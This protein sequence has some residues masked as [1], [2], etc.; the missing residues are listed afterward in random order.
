MVLVQDGRLD[1][2]GRVSE[3]LDAAPAS[4]RAITI[5]HLLTHTAGLARESPGFDPMKAQADASVV[6]AAYETPLRFAPGS[7]WEYSNLGYYVLAEII[8]H[9]SG[10]PWSEFMRERVFG[11]AGMTVTAPTD[12]ALPNRATGYTGNDNA[13]PA[14]DDWIAVRPSGAFL[15][16]VGDLAKWDARLDTDSVLTEASRRQ[17][18]SPVQL[19]DG[20]AHPYGFGW[21]VETRK[22]GRRVVWH[23]GGLPGFASYFG[24]FLDD[25]VSVIVLTNGNDVDVIALANGL[26]N[27]YLQA[28]RAAPR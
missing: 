8:T 21:H 9:V 23:G 11:P 14:D 3:Y 5:R 19:S 12:V 22:D 26:A 6:E 1:V 13:E 25:R 18:W 16:T 15:S 27:L 20:G 2:D 4:W 10:E 17:M 24:R 28:D 7:R